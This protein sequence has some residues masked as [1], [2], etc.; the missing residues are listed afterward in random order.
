[1]GE[2]GYVP[3]L[4][5]SG[6]LGPRP[7]PIE[8]RAG[9]RVGT[10]GGYWRFTVGQRRGHRASARPGRCYVLATDAAR[11]AVTVGPREA[12]A[13]HDAGLDPDAGCTS[14]LATAPWRC[15][16]ATGGAR[17]RGRVRADGD[18]GLGVALGEPAD[19]VAPGQTAALYRD[20]RLVAAGTIAVPRPRTRT[21]RR[22]VVDWSD[23][24]KLALSFFLIVTGLGLALPVPAH[25]AASSAV[26][27][28]R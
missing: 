25:G 26:S 24:L 4:E 8:D 6:G 18:G 23:V 11:N 13:R 9:R 15:G 1:M 2:G 19:G 12:L 10:H 20:G 16:C 3:F 27:A 17:C 28:S 21:R 14:E 7:G 22:L 5:R